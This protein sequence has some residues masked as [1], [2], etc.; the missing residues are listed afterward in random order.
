MKIIHLGDLHLGIKFHKRSLIEDQR[1]A[2]QQIINLAAEQQCCTVIAGDVF[3]TVNPSIEAQELWFWFL[4]ELGDA[5]IN[6]DTITIVIPGNHDSAARLGMDSAFLLHKRIHVTPKENVFQGFWFK[7][8]DFVAIPFLKPATL[9]HRWGDVVDTYDEAFKNVLSVVEETYDKTKAV[10]I[11]HQT[12]EGGKTGESEFKPFMPDAISLG[13]FKGYPLVLVGHLHA[14]QKLDNAVYSGSLLPYA[15][16]D[17]YDAGISIWSNDSGTWT[18]TREPLNV[19][20]PLKTITGGLAHCLSQ[21][22]PDCYVKVKLTDGAYIDDALPK[23]Q[24]HF[25]LLM[26]VITDATDT[27]EAD[28][29][30]PIGTFSSV[31]EALVSFCEHLEIPEFTGRRKELIQEALDAYTTTKN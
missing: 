28:L 2:L 19:L 7:G 29:D 3:D 21:D 15:F 26:S 6:N 14:H 23:L 4:N 31:P 18:H 1:S 30:K 8:V 25:P 17:E 10:I 16:G 11:C 22:A 9:E 13:N 12:L 5:N 20:H 27:W 24:E